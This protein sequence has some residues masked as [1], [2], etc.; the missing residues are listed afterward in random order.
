MST[1]ALSELKVLKPRPGTALVEVLGEHDLATR[2]E[3]EMLFSR[4][5][6]ENDLV[7]IDVSEAAFIDSAFLLNLKEAQQAAQE[8]GRT[9][10]L[11]VGTEP[12]VK[13]LLE[14]TGFLTYFDHVSSRE[15][16]LA[17]AP[18]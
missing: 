11:Q 18:E 3:T 13:R 16:A 10:L 8:R 12:A 2:D 9:V 4:L 14:I 5:V 15:D 1:P 17:W 7:I 6:A